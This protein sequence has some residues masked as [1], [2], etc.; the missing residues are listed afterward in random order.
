MQKGGWGGGGEGVQIA[1]KI[2]YTYLTEGPLREC[3]P[4]NTNDISNHKHFVPPQFTVTRVDEEDGE[5]S[6]VG[7]ALCGAED[8]AASAPLTGRSQ[9]AVRLPVPADSGT[10]DAES[11]YGDTLTQTS[12]T[13]L[14]SRKFKVGFSAENAL[15]C[16]FLFFLL[17]KGTRGK[18]QIWV[19]HVKKDVPTVEYQGAIL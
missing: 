4:F 17:K 6:G 7:D 5:T 13:K 19:R 2:A 10:S 15:G 3:L 16:F 9:G 14:L 18:V 8:G 1:C 11:S 12:I